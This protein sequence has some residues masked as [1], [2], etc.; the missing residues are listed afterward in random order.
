MEKPLY[1]LRFGLL[2]ISSFFFF[3]SFSMIIPELPGHLAKMGGKEYVG[4]IISLFTL[5]AGISRPFSGKL[6]DT[7]GRIPVIFLGV[8]M[9]FICG[10]FYPFLTTVVG[11][12]SLR[13]V[14]GFSTGFTPTGSTS[15]IADI[16]PT[17]RRGEAM[18]I[19]GLISNLGTAIGQGIGSKIAY[20][21]SMDALFYTSAGAGL[22]SI[23][24]ILRMKEPL[25]NPVPF[26]WSLLKINRN[27]VIDTRVLAPSLALL[28]TVY[29]FGTIVTIIPDYSVYIGIRP[30]NKGLFFT[31]F[32]MSSIAMRFL[33]GKISDK[34]GRLIVLKVGLTILIISLTWIALAE[35]PTQLLIGGA[36]YGVSVGINAPTL[37]AW[38]V[39][40]SDRDK[41]GQGIA[42]MFIALEVGIGLGAFFTGAIY[43]GQEEYMVYTFYV[44]GVI[45]L[46]AL[47]FAQFGVK[48][49]LPKKKYETSY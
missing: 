33:A 7:V 19:A 13:L 16:V 9:S 44:A 37:F 49:F 23:L 31:C 25:K 28:L 20:A 40:L 11:F 21:Y 18:G 39:D 43:A 2:C 5:T 26:R 3:M 42:T 34:Y 1:T 30:D 6:A 15:F 38:T 29:A 35:T 22:F 46:L 4:L 14:H 36:L 47:I 32:V 17:H 8:L 10:V 24:I 27:E 45:A 41:I 48:Y 12:L